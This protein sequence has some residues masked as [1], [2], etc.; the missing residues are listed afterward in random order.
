MRQDPRT[1]LD[2]TRAFVRDRCDGESS[3][4][5]W[6]HIHRVCRTAV[7]IGRE[8]GVDLSVVELAALLHDVADW[9]FHD[10]DEDIGP[11]TAASWLRSL[12]IDDATVEHVSEIVRDISF[13]GAGVPTPMRTRE[14]E[15]VQDADRLDGLGAIGIARAFAFGGFRGQPLHDPSAE[16]FLAASAEDYKAHRGSTINHFS[17]RILLH[18]DRMN[19]AT[20]RRMARDRHEFMER[21]LERFHAEW[22]GQV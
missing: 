8:E 13:K 17:E 15:V 4:H 6:W 1:V 7:A 10:G 18:A 2:Q 5:D 12:G 11:R 20:G 3:G 22:D 9:K 21:F 16:P 14:G 19:T